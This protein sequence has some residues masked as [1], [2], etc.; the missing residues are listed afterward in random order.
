MFNQ[1]ILLLICDGMADRPLRAFNNRT[2]LEKAE[3]PNL[4][5]LAKKGVTGLMDPISPG[6]SPPSDSS[7]LFIFGYESKDHPG[8]G[9]IEALGASIPL[10]RESVA[11]RCNIA[12]VERKSNQLIVK[13]RRA[14]RIKGKDAEEAAK[15]V[16]EIGEI[17]GV[18]VKFFHTLEHRG[19]LVLEGNLSSQVT[20]MDPQVT[21]LP[22]AKAKPKI[23]A[24]KD[25]KAIK[26]AEVLN[27]FVLKTFTLLN[28]ASFNVE[29]TS[30]GLP[31]GNIILLRGAGKLT[32]A[33]SFSEKWGLKSAAV[34]GAPLYKGL[35]KFAGMQLHE[36]PGATGL[37]DTDYKGKINKALDLLGEYDFVFVHIKASDVA[38]HKKDCLLKKK[39]IEKIDEA[40]EPLV[41]TKDVLKIITADHTTSS[42]LGIHTGEPVP[43]LINGLSVRVDKVEK[44]GER[45]AANG[46]LNRIKGLDLMPILISLSNRSIEYG[47]RVTPEEKL[48]LDTNYEPLKL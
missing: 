33:K 40:V 1:K 6:V 11:F 41:E 12:T 29:R 22:V 16:N 42:E 34:A 14:G 39:V 46:G 38:S 5:F 7:H 37:V 4:D 24:G 9:V 2:P 23:E 31:P 26:T 30:K 19:V 47:V 43:L 48:F 44:F 18:K 35:A 28:E 27:K 13:D 20:D 15:I 25:L 45:E 36:T 21:N 8:R 17:D 3:S 10:N 32:F